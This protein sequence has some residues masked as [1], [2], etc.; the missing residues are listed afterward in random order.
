MTCTAGYLPHD[1]LRVATTASVDYA[2]RIQIAS[3]ADDG[4]PIGFTVPKQTAGL[5]PTQGTLYFGMGV[6][7]VG[8][9]QGRCWG[10]LMITVFEEIT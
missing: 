5:D 9:P 6:S 10:N 2:S 1:D 7:D 3:T 8:N 4:T